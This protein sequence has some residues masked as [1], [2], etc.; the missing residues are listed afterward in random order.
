[1]GKILILLSIMLISG[2]ATVTPYKELNLDTTSD[3]NIPKEGKA[4]IYVFQYKTG[5]F[6]AEFDVN[7]EIKGMPK[8][9]LNTGEYAYLEIDPGLY[10]YKQRGGL[11]QSFG[12][13]QFEAGKNYFFCAK[14]LNLSDFIYL[15][16]KQNQIN[17]AKKDILNGKYE[18]NTVD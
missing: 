10:E 7:F 1:M 4:G 2:C 15:V 11:I 18:L 12:S 8:I 17:Q 14:L 13:I 3:F 6:G 16:T 5:I 9:P